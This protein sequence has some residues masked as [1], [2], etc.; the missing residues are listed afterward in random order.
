MPHPA[1]P[2]DQR[3]GGPPWLAWPPSRVPRCTASAAA[4]AA[5][6]AGAAAAICGLGL[7]L[8]ELMVLRILQV[9]IGQVDERSGSVVAVKL[10]HAIR[11]HPRLGMCSLVGLAIGCFLV[12][13]GDPPLGRHERLGLNH[14]RLDEYSRHRKDSPVVGISIDGSEQLEHL[15]FRGGA[16]RSVV[17]VRSEAVLSAARGDIDLPVLDFGRSIPIRIRI[18]HG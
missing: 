4:S 16:E 5:A 10:R 8:T 9:V 7:L 17:V 2:P 3:G 18:I 1:K 15:G 6:A 12:Q 11:R 14:E 13:G